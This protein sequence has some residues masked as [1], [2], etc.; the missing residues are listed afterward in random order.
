MLRV[1]IVPRK[2]NALKL[3]LF[4]GFG[5][6]DILELFP[7]CTVEICQCLFLE[8]RRHVRNNDNH[9][10]SIFVINTDSVSEKMKK[11]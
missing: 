9:G 3:M 7:K 2:M 6:V 10:L 8:I 4:L 11:K 1:P 5:G